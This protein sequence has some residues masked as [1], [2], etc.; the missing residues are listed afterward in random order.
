MPHLID[1][2]LI[3]EM[4]ARWKEGRGGRRREREG[5]GSG[6]GKREA[7]IRKGTSG[8]H[9]LDGECREILSIAYI[10]P[11]GNYSQLIQNP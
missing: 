3:T 4:Q 7:K 6:R 2:E 11:F 1:K 9:Q 10:P 8:T 5:E